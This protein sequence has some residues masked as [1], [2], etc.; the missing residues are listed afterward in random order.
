MGIAGPDLGLVP[1]GSVSFLVFKPGQQDPIQLPSVTLVNGLG[2]ARVRGESGDHR[3]HHRSLVCGRHVPQGHRSAVRHREPAPRADGVR[4]RDSRLG[5][6]AQVTAP[7]TVELG[8]PTSVHVKVIGAVTAT[9]IVRVQLSGGGNVLVGEELALVNGEVDLPIDPIWLTIGSREYV[10]QSPRRHAERHHL[11]AVHHRRRPDR[12]HDHADDLE[13]GRC[14]ALPRTLRRARAVRRPRHRIRRYACRHRRLLPRRHPHRQ[15]RARRA[16]QREHVDGRRPG[17]LGRDPRRVHPVQ[18]SAGQQLRHPRPLLDPPRSAS[19]CRAR[20]TAG[21][22]S[23]AS[24]SRGCSSTG[25]RS[26][27]SG[28]RCARRTDRAARSRSATE[29]AAPAR[30]SSSRCRPRPRT[31]AATCPS[32]PSARTRSARA[33][34]VT[35]TGRAA[36]RRCSRPPSSEAPRPWRS[37][38][39]TATTGS[40]S[41]RCR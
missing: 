11:R 10:V 6:S 25:S 31:R 26:N 15:R 22:A 35:S 37:S 41:P 29:P 39:R 36:P 5:A 38:P 13:P 23:R 16:G 19:R 30:R 24:T 3:R 9:G 8:V 21:S 27:S 28:L 20:S 17:V 33:T 4:R 1:G 34:R 40:A 2:R 18:R 14:N 12:H 32:A 7:S